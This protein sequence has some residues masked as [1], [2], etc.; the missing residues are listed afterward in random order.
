MLKTRK[1]EEKYFVCDVC[2]TEV[3]VEYKF[4]ESKYHFCKEHE[5]LF[6]VIEKLEK[7]GMEE[8]INKVIE[9]SK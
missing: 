7:L 8:E 5:D 4:W 9:K 2:G 6:K 3:P 1:I